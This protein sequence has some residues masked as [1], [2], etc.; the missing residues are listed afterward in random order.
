MPINQ[1]FLQEL[2]SE[3]KSTRRSLQRCPEEHFDWKP[4]E[5]S[6][7]LGRLASHIAE[8]TNM[9]TLALT[10]SELDFVKR[11]YKPSIA[12]T[13]QELMKIFEDNLSRAKEE[14]QKAD[15]DAFAQDW[16]LRGGERIYFTLKKAEAVRTM[17]LN[18]IIHHRGQ[19]SVY[20]R[21]L[22]VPVPGMYGPTADEPM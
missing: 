11:G 10:S 18:H 7:S 21:L 20:L 1:S 13:N 9:I 3:S 2:E 6:Y 14:L 17:A 16:Q 12:T 5:K 15:D 19:L 4:H 8:L 22:N